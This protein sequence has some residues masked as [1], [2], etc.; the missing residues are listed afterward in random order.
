M[1][2]YSLQGFYPLLHTTMTYTLAIQL[3]WFEYF[4]KCLENWATEE[5]AKKEMMT[6]E[7]LEEIRNLALSFTK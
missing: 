3:A 1:Q 4:K 6:K 5:Q 2:L 7:A